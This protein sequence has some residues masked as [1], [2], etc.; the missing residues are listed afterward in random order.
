MQRHDE[1]KMDRTCLASEVARPRAKNHTRI[2]S[3]LYEEVAVQAA[4]VTNKKA[5]DAEKPGLEEDGR[6]SAWL[7]VRSFSGEPFGF[8]SMECSGNEGNV[9]VQHGGGRNPRGT[10]TEHTNSN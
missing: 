1:W 2:G 4:Q 5:Y 3:N 8:R 6:L 7:W 9:Q 10:E